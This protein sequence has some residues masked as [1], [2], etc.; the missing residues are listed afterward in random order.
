MGVDDQ[1]Q[2]AGVGVN[3]VRGLAG[4]ADEATVDQGRIRAGQEEQV[5]VGERPLLPGH[6]GR[7]AVAITHR[8]RS[9]F[10]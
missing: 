9:S 4:V 7:Q 1:R 8:A 3:L 6:S 10:G 5:G 2:L